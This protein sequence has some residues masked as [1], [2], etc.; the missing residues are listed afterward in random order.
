[1]RR[2]ELN[3]NDI[4]IVRLEQFYPF[5]QD[6]LKK[7]LAQYS[8]AKQW[9]WVQEEPQNMG[10]WQFIRS[11]LEAIIGK[12]LM[13]IGRKEASSP[14]TGF[15]AIHKLEQAAIVDQAIGPPVPKPEG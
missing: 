13:Y 4:V 9:F 7:I 10:G 11:R 6:Q 1:M 2:Q 5:P 3:L 14:A 15:P 12:P 8:M